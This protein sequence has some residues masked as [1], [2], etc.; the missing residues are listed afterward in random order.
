MTG[1]P[2]KECA[3]YVPGELGQ[4]VKMSWYIRARIISRA[5]M[6]RENR[7]ERVAS[8][9]AFPHRVTAPDLAPVPMLQ[10]PRIALFPGVLGNEEDQQ[11]GNGEVEGYDGEAKAQLPA[12]LQP[13]QRLPDTVGL[14]LHGVGVEDGGVEVPARHGAVGRRCAGRGVRVQILHPSSQIVKSKG[15]VRAGRKI[16]LGRDRLT[17]W[18]FLSLCRRWRSAFVIGYGL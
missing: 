17:H 8:P 5:R 1:R 18:P 11:P 2:C 4:Q 7:A 12:L 10:S 9:I 15:L 13:P 14:H 16:F 3:D 6:V